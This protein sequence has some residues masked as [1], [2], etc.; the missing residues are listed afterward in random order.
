MKI[1][2]PCEICKK[3]KLWFLISYREMKPNE[4]M[5]M[6]RSKAKMC[7][8]CFKG[9]NKHFGGKGGKAI[10][11]GKNSVAIP[12]LNGDAS[13]EEKLEYRKMAQDAIKRHMDDKP[14]N[15]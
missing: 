9:V 4:F 13:D 11:K 14:E 1:L 3:N 12:G 6:I 5:P 7:G 2:K 10:V 8:K 15:R